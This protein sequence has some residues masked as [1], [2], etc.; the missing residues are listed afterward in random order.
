MAKYKLESEA[1][2]SFGSI[3]KYGLVMWLIMLVLK[4]VFLGWLN[5]VSWQMGFYYLLIVISARKLSRKFGVINILEAGFI[6][7]IWGLMILFLDSLIAK[8]F[9]VATVFVSKAYWWSYFVVFI[10]IFFLHQKRH[11]AIR[12]EQAHHH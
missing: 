3:L 5:P 9:L 2:I 6:G 12:Q 1:L 10:A 4:W 7:I 11:V 8:R